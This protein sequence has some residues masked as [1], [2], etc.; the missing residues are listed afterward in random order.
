VILAVYEDKA[1]LGQFDRDKKILSPAR[2]RAPVDSL[3]NITMENVGPL[4]RVTT[5]P[6]RPGP[7][8]T[9]VP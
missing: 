2:H 6:T 1:I 7:Q 9:P 8:T 5:T 4:T 3:G